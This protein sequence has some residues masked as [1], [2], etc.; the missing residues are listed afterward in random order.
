ME[1][2]CAEETL[3]ITCL[4]GKNFNH[5]IKNQEIDFLGGFS[6]LW[7]KGLCIS[8]GSLKSWWHP[9]G[10]L[11]ERHQQRRLKMQWEI[12]RQTH[13]RRIDKC[14]EKFHFIQQ[15]TFG[16]KERKYLSIYLN[17]WYRNSDFGG[18]MPR[19]TGGSPTSCKPG[20]SCLIRWEHHLVLVSPYTLSHWMGTLCTDELKNNHV[21]FSSFRGIAL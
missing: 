18:K 14:S 9:A 21:H 8:F 11:H 16:G 10:G 20:L 12:C 5:L 15:N 7:E 13:D 17:F 2:E 1:T 4:W 3:F 19:K 6:S